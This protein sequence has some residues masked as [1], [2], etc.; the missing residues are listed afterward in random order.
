M[1]PLL[2]VVDLS[3]RFGTLTALEKINFEVFPGEIVG[4]A[5]RSGSGKSVLASILGGVIVPSS[6]EIHYDGQQPSWPLRAHDLDI[7]VISQEPHLATNLNI[8]ENI[9]LGTKDQRF[10]R[11]RWLRIPKVTQMD[12]EAQ[13]LL[14][15]LNVQ[16]HSLHEKVANLSSEQRQLVSI[17]RVM[18][19]PGKLI[20]VDEPTS[21]L[22][23]RHQQRLLELIQD[24]QRVGI[25]II[26][27]SKNLQDLMAVTDRIITL[28]RGRQ[29]ATY[30]TDEVSRERIVA[31]LVGAASPNQM[32][33]AIWAL[34]S[35]YQA[36][37]QSTRLRHQQELLERNLEQQDTLNQQ[38]VVQLADQVEA[39]DQA[40]FAL[41]EAQR[42][43]L[44]EREQERKHLARELHDQVIQDLLSL[45][46]ELEELE[47]LLHQSPAKST[48]QVT[49][50]P[51]REVVIEAEL[52]TL[53]NV[54]SDIRLLVEDV[55]RICGNLRPPTIDSLGLG[56]ALQSY[57]GEWSERTGIPVNLKLDPKLRRLPEA[58]ELS[59]FRIVQEGLSNVRK[60]AQSTESVIVQLTHAS[61][62]LLMV[63]IADNGPGHAETLDLS[64]LAANGHYGLLGIS[65]RVA[66]LGGRLSVQ[67]NSG[68]GVTVRAE[69]PHPRIN[70]SQELE[71]K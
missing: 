35:Y 13:R 69:I 46:Y 32:T 21:P 11:N 60:H 67:N 41:Q 58:T 40:N 22:S 14:R 4:L 10:L 50:Q 44:T 26:F 47:S 53:T 71:R 56:A 51:S 5:G 63:S 66:L 55:R 62:R 19:H 27:S 8:T 16:F 38:L 20:F 43:L 37:E 30:R 57:T 28:R 15:S 36:R 3:K 2:K 45:N 39:L 17:A 52:D 68:D 12:E 65:E 6:G 31:D 9:F 42:R 18:A 61:P 49:D 33:P 34:D 25:G 70:G 64:T 29:V 7:Q 24:W 59:V 23:Y 48:A 54:R 1:S